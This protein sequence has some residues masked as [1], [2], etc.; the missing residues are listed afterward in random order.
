MRPKLPS[1]NE[2]WARTGHRNIDEAGFSES[3]TERVP[4]IEA[5]SA[6]R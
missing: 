1:R 4:F 2:S 5:E 3:G 6:Q